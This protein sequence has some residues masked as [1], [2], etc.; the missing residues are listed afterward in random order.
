MMARRS[1]MIACG[2]R[3]QRRGWWFSSVVETAASCAQNKVEG[4]QVAPEVPAASTHTRTIEEKNVVHENA[5]QYVQCSKVHIHMSTYLNDSG[6]QPPQ[7]CRAV[8]ESSTTSASSTVFAAPTAAHETNGWSNRAR[9][10]PVAFGM[11]PTHRIMEAKAL[12]VW[13]L[14]HRFGTMARITRR[15]L[16]LLFA[17]CWPAACSSVVVSSGSDLPL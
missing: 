12:C 8:A 14:L 4:G 9:R 6:A 13:M 7:G 5:V 2:N 17:F 10:T 1:T 11:C 3:R 15:R 16:F